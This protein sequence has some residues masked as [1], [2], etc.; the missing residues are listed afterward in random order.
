MKLIQFLEMLIGCLVL[1]GCAIWES[2]QNHPA[3]H[4]HPDTFDAR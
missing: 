4:A 2:L 3:E 1:V